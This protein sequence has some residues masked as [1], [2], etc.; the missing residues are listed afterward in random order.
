MELGVSTAVEAGPKRVVIAD[1]DADIRVLIAIA[2]RKAGLVV[3]AEESD[4]VA[5][6]DAVRR[7]QPDLAILDVSMPA[8]TGIEVCRTV[9]GDTSL[10]S[11]RLVLLS[12]GADDRARGIGLASGADHYLIKP[13]SPKA[14]AVTLAEMMGHA[15]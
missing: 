6:L 4:G 13:F 11:V 7:V 1:D 8:M 12:A 15:E 5:A 2:A 14:L 10:D 9:R 3:V